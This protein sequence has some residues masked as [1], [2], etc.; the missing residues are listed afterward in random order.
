V[1]KLL[2]DT[3]HLSAA[4]EAANVAR[5]RIYGIPKPSTLNPQPLKPKRNPKP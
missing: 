2:D 4:R 1:L 3:E 5:S